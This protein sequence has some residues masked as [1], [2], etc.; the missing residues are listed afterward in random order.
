MKRSV[1]DKVK[2]K[3]DPNPKTDEQRKKTLTVIQQK[4]KS[5]TL[6]R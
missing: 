1:E 6:V 4:N 2:E 3:T 5:Y